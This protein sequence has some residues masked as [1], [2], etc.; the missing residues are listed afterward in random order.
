MKCPTCQKA[1][2]TANQLPV[3]YSYDGAPAAIDNIRGLACESCGAL[4]IDS[5]EAIRITEFMLN[6]QRKIMTGNG[7]DYV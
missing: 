4:V 6:Y 3:Q 5:T 7:C 1:E 2:L